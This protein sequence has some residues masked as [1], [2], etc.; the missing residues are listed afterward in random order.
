[1]TNIERL[2][3]ADKRYKAAREAL[4]GFA[5][6]H[7]PRRLLTHFEG[8][9]GREVL[10]HS[11]VYGNPVRPRELESQFGD[12]VQRAQNFLIAI[13]RFRKLFDADF[14]A[15][16][17]WS[18]AKYQDELDFEAYARSIDETYRMID[19]EMIADVR[20]ECRELG[21]VD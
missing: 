5:A 9:V 20:E 6:F 11:V 3:L 4:V 14:D 1:M 13:P 12:A 7:L 16:M 21:L 10:M 2:K 8:D 19:R 18:D 15:Y 17:E